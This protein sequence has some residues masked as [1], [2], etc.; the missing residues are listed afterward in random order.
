MIA[1]GGFSLRTDSSAIPLKRCTNMHPMK[2]AFILLLTATLLAACSSRYTTQPLSYAISP[3]EA[4][5]LWASHDIHSYELELEM[6]G[7]FRTTYTIVVIDD[8][9][10]K[11]IYKGRGLKTTFW[12]DR[13]VTGMF[14][15]IDTLQLKHLEYRQGER[16]T[17]SHGYEVPDFQVTVRY[18]SL[19][20]Y[21][22]LVVV[23][24]KASSEGPAVRKVLTFSP[25]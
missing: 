19:Y 16:D 12:Q 22:A 15:E 8:S 20:G 23:D 4:R 2:A 9:V 3:E 17:T 5:T 7:F 18:D 1:A 6:S 25:R 10:V 21:P 24:D 14:R 13:S 11:V